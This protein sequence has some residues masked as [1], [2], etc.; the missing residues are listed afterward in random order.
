MAEMT[1]EEVRKRYEAARSAI[2]GKVWDNLPVTE[3]MRIRHLLEHANDPLPDPV[4][5][6][7]EEWGVEYCGKMKPEGMRFSVHEM[8]LAF[9]A[10]WEARAKQIKREPVDG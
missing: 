5:E 8:R 7:F 9:R 4:D 6:A 1:E 3:R 10:G 2:G